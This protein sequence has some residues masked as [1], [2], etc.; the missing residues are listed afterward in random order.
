MEARLEG[1]RLQESLRPGMHAALEGAKAT[2]GDVESLAWLHGM[3]LCVDEVSPGSRARG[4]G[5]R[6]GFAWLQA[7]GAV[8]TRA[9]WAAHQ[10]HSCPRCWQPAPLRPACGRP[11]HP[12]CCPPH[13]P[14]LPCS[15]PAAASYRHHDHVGASPGQ[16]LVRGLAQGLGHDPEAGL[17]GGGR[18]AFAA[19]LAAEFSQSLA[20]ATLEFDLDS[21]QL[22]PWFR[23]LSPVHCPQSR[24]SP[25]V[26]RKDTLLLWC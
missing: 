9:R 6:P 7:A 13:P 21:Q 1:F 26:A 4:F 10:R 19:V 23:S 14:L 8:C 11:R 22:A 16:G 12:A 2:L 18:H 25:A 3:M 24:H 20:H 17:T 5:A 15:L